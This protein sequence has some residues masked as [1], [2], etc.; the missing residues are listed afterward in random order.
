[1]PSQKCGIAF[2]GI[3]RLAATSLESV[4]L[5]NKALLERNS[6]HDA[7]M[8]RVLGYGETLFVGE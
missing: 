2:S 4:E 1:M 8:K 5:V 7:G 3:V 6:D